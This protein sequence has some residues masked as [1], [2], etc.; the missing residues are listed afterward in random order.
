MTRPYFRL[1]G[2]EM[3]HRNIVAATLALV[4]A[5]FAPR[6]D[7]RPERAIFIAARVLSIAAVV[8]KE[9]LVIHDPN[10][11]ASRAVAE[12]LV[13][14]RSELQLGKQGDAVPIRLM[15][16]NALEPFEEQQIV[17][18]TQGIEAQFADVARVASESKA[19]TVSL[20][21]ECARSG[22]CVLSVQVRPKLEIFLSQAA[23]TAAGLAFDAKFRSFVTEV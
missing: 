10:N 12:E 17:F 11:E 4:F 14:D 7:A 15:D 21:P 2:S 23:A 20:D 5:V 22:H 9:V 18:L 13:G 19:I 16:V 3:K 6:A 1:S 8:P